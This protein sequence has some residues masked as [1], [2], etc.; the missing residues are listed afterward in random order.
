MSTQNQSMG[1]LFQCQILTPRNRF[2]ELQD[3]S[4]GLEKF[5]S[6]GQVE[7]RKIRWPWH[8]TCKSICLINMKMNSF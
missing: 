2:K 5:F 4:Y 1:I 7:R 6:V 8:N 3:T